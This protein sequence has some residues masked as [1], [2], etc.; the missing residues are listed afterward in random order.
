MGDV[1]TALRQADVTVLLVGHRNCRTG[2]LAARARRL[3]HTTGL[4]PGEQ[5][6]RL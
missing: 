5:V 4:V 2:T 1:E 6:Q 3:L